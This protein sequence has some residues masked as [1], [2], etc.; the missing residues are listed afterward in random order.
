MTKFPEAEWQG[1]DI[2]PMTALE[3]IRRRTD[4]YLG[5]EQKLPMLVAWAMLDPVVSKGTR[6]TRIDV[7]WNDDG[8]VFIMDDDLSLPT[9]SGD[10]R[11]PGLKEILTRLYAG[12]TPRGA[13][14][15]PVVAL[16]EWFLVEQH[17]PEG[18]YRLRLE[19]GVPQPAEE[20]PPSPPWRT[21]ISFKPDMQFFQAE[22]P[23]SET[24]LVRK[25]QQRLDYEARWRQEASPPK[26]V[27]TVLFQPGTNEL[28]L[29]PG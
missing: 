18:T 16:C 9:E 27:P 4:M 14:L 10:A 19:S 8:I 25:A 2:K 13:N 24:S 6:W 17:R 1:S 23:L 21:C 11:L 12:A 26:P 28:T 3:A 5:P 20:A 7:R 15:L 29:L 22:E